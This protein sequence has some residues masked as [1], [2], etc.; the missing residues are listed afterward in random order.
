MLQVGWVKCGDGTN[1]C[2]FASVNL[3]DVT[4][5]GVYVIWH[6]GD[7]ARCVYVGQGDVAARLKAH[8][9]DSRITDYA[10]S[11]TLRVTW[12]AVPAA[13]RDGVERYLADYY[14]PLVGDAHPA[15]APIQV[16]L[17]A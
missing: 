11:G 5:Q 4:T 17:V 14:A 9:N 13:Q 6:D 7:P 1:W 16:N 12:A 10:R 8:R 3:D 15:V 2:P